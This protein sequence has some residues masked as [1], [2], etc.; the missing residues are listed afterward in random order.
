MKLVRK[1]L[2]V[3]IYDVAQTESYLENMARKGL[4]LKKIG[5]FAYFEKG[6]SENISYRLEPIT[7]AEK[8][9]SEEMLNYYEDYGWEYVCTIAKLFHIYR[10][11]DEE[12]VEIH[13]DPILQ[14]YT[15]DYLNK[16]LKLYS[17]LCCLMLPLA[18]ILLV[19]PFFN[20]HPLLF[21]IK[22]GQITYQ[23]PSFLLCIFA[24]YSM[25]TNRRKVKE[26]LKQLKL[27]VPMSH[28]EKYKPKYFTYVFLTIIIVMSGMHIFSSFYSL[29][30]MWD[31]N[32]YEYEGKLPT[33]NLE[34]IENNDNFIKEKDYYKDKDYNSFISHEWS[35]LAP[36]M[37]EI[38]EEGI[39]KGETWE[40]GSGEYSPSLNTDFYELQFKFLAEPLIEELISDKLDFY[41]FESI[42]YEEI[43]DTNFDKA[44]IVKTKHVQM[45][46]A[47][48]DNK[49]INMSY[50]GYKELKDF[51]DDIE[52]AV[53]NF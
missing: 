27:G 4:F 32:L 28:K 42:V 9:P 39:V 2:P 17:W 10:S 22:F 49:V 11:K 14:G 52:K 34:K 36:N 37:Y 1:L 18:I 16:R 29:S 8:K 40:D 44:V 5:T 7:R 50:Y 21:A 31:K 33:I 35:Q 43:S 13:T 15:Y 48:K 25:I 30:Q 51:V 12:P 45:L 20:D 53:S 19:I 38:H 24:I 46:F 6:K 26:I 47:I 23:I 41:G 3:N